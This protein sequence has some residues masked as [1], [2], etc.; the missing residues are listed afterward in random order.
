MTPFQKN[1]LILNQ[2]KFVIGFV[3][4]G[5]AFVLE[6]A[7]GT[8]IAVTFMKVKKYR[9]KKYVRLLQ[10]KGIV[11]VHREAFDLKGV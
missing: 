1:T 7:C 6:D 5:L 3:A 2:D 4:A 8:N 11:L 10:Q 9:Y